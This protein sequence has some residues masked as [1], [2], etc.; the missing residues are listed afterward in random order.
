ML[1]K[2]KFLLLVILVEVVTLSSANAAFCSL[3]DPVS[4]IQ[5][6]YD[7]GYEFRSLVS[8]ITEEDRLTLKDKLSFTLHQ[9]EV[10]QHTLY[11]L[12]KNNKHVGF[13]QAR[14]EWA[15]WGLVEIAW[16]INVDR[17]IKGFHYQR[18]RSP[19]CNENTIKNINAVLKDKSFSQLQA[20]LSENGEEL[21][22]EGK[23]AFQQ[24]PRL[25]LLTLR[26]A[27]KTL[28]IT[29]IS[30]KGEIDKITHLEQ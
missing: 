25:A 8:T 16:A 9:S 19:E 22:D 27:L 7:D 12:S 17:S 2:L 20:L 5:M 15:K 11:V 18:C 21:S 4:A 26:S 10:G 14:S 23:K 13:L 28:A 29:D 1:N 30:W 3:R 6:L 24:T